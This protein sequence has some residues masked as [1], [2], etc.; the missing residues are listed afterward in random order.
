MS[1]YTDEKIHAY[2]WNELPI[3]QGVIDLVEDL[4]HE[5]KQPIHDD[6]IPLLSGIWA[7]L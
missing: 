6:K 4:A 5:E 7:W 2:H 3:D 1:L